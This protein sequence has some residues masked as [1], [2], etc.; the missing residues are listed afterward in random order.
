MPF[1]TPVRLAVLLPF[2]SI[3][4]YYFG[5][6]PTPPATFHVLH[7]RAPT[8]KDSLT[9]CPAGGVAPGTSVDRKPAFW[10][11]GIDISKEELVI[12]VNDTDVK[13]RKTVIDIYPGIQ[14]PTANRT[15][16]KSNRTIIEVHSNEK[17]G[18]KLD[19]KCTI[20]PENIIAG[21]DMHQIWPCG[22]IRSYRIPLASIDHF[23]D[24]LPIPDLP[25]RNMFDWRSLTNLFHIRVYQGNEEVPSFEAQPV[26]LAV[27]LAE[28]ININAVGDVFSKDNDTFPHLALS[29]RQHG[30]NWRKRKMVVHVQA[31][32][33][34]HYPAL[35]RFTDVNIPGMTLDKP[36]RY[37]T[38]PSDFEKFCYRGQ[39]KTAAHD[40][41]NIMW[42]AVYS[43]K[44]PHE[45]RDLNGSIT[46][47]FAGICHTRDKNCNPLPHRVVR[48]QLPDG[49][50]SLTSIFNMAEV[51]INGN[52]VDDA[53]TTTKTATASL[54]VTPSLSPE[55]RS[56]E[57]QRR[58]EIFKQETLNEKALIDY[59]EKEFKYLHE[60]KLRKREGLRNG[61][62]NAQAEMDNLVKSIADHV[63]AL[64]DVKPEPRERSYRFRTF[65]LN[66]ANNASHEY[67][68]NHAEILN[69]EEIHPARLTS[70]Y[71][72][73]FYEAKEA[74][75][76]G[77]YFMCFL[78]AS[79][80]GVNDDSSAS[81]SPYVTTGRLPIFWDFSDQ[82]SLAIQGEGVV[83]YVPDSGVTPHSE[84]ENRLFYGPNAF[85]TT[86]AS[87]GD[88]LNP[89]I[90]PV[91]HGQVVASII[92]GKPVGLAPRAKIVS[93]KVAHIGLQTYPSW[94]QLVKNFVV[95]DNRF[96]GHKKIFNL[97][98]GKGMYSMNQNDEIEQV[99]RN[100]D[101]VVVT[102][103]G[104]DRREPQDACRRSPS[105]ASFAIT[106]GALLHPDTF[107]P[108]YADRI[109]M[110]SYRGKCVKIWAPGHRLKVADRSNFNMIAD[111]G[112]DATSWAAPHTS[113]VIAA[114]WSAN[115]S[116]KATDI[117]RVLLGMATQAHFLDDPWPIEELN[118]MDIDPN[119]ES[120]YI[121]YNV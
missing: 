28:A 113:G 118:R 95:A 74:L 5:Y 26:N 100:D 21:P 73:A 87:D 38:Q 77:N 4:L 16:F 96:P 34:L 70:A 98:L 42:S 30:G 22:L 31:S 8:T 68:R 69:V 3:Y 71:G 90:T 10:S 47:T 54:P 84:F 33:T 116:L 120:P 105:S 80:I 27:A 121:L 112:L 65:L 91:G 108:P 13:G 24:W 39:S 11:A 62:E 83:V 64:Q 115:P 88:T 29:F 57:K 75:T 46:A 25:E 44:G 1:L 117:E 107:G 18:M 72:N 66:L 78:T 43:L 86:G 53:T 101:I 2:F 76:W 99:T 23:C 14:K 82:F 89:D 40:R 119:E 111:M 59:K 92:A 106:T 94:W 67:V 102:A 61:Y 52:S 63:G 79:P 60:V 48:Y 32:A 114:P 45:F 15:K 9:G 19:A 17:R 103:A 41:C 110:V 97:S 58:K 93:I 37:V 50:A 55:Q 12:L 7:R 20:A 56:V 104:N 36:S 85:N 109:S 6:G 35:Y 81:Q 49:L 51:K